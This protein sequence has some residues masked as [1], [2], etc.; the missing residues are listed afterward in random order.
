MFVTLSG[1]G[2]FSASSICLDQ[3]WGFCFSLTLVLAFQAFHFEDSWG[4]LIPVTK[5]SGNRHAGLGLSILSCCLLREPRVD[6]YLGV[7]ADFFYGCNLW[8]VT[9]CIR[10][11]LLWCCVSRYLVSLQIKCP[12][13]HFALKFVRLNTEKYFILFTVSRKNSVW[14]RVFLMH[15]LTSGWQDLIFVIYVFNKD[16]VLLLLKQ[17][18]ICME[19]VLVLLFQWLDSVCLT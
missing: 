19:I 11:A 12:N 17:I 6:I 4:L 1:H 14:A 10:T 5:F 7:R 13:C 18:Y 3:S 15:S 2:S 16:L 9:G 8:H